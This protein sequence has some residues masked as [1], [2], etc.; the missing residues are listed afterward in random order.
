MDEPLSSLDAKLR[1]D[2]RLE[3]KRIQQDLGATM[4]YVTHDQTEALTLATRIGVLDHGRLVQV[5]SPRDIY[6]NP[7]TSTVAARLGSPRIN[8]LPRAALGEWPAPAGAATVGVR[9]EH[10]QLHADGTAPTPHLRAEVH[11]IEILSDQRLVHLTLG[12]RAGTARSAPPSTMPAFEPGATVGVELRRAL[13]FDAEGAPRLIGLTHTV[14]RTLMPQT[15]LIHAATQML[16]DHVDE[17]TALD[18]AIGDGDHGLNMRRGA[19]AIQAKLP[20]WQGK[21]LERHAQGHGHGLHVDHRRL[22]GAG[23]RHLA[24]DAGQGAAGRSR[25]R[26]TCRAPCRPASRR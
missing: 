5:G 14:R 6:E 20:E 2:L 8:L 9:A 11:R 24:G 26:P 15:P 17:L 16:I 21:P 13:W 1:N 25:R 19:L 18:Q 4:L 22:V 12:R 10:L 7:L 3:L 23:V